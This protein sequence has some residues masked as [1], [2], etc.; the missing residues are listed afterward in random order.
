[1]EKKADSSLAII[2]TPVSY[3]AS[4]DLLFTNYLSLGSGNQSGFKCMDTVH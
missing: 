3:I 2:F 4:F 1:M